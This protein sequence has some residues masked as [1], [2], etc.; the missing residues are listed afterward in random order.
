VDPRRWPHRCA[1]SRAR[2]GRWY[3]SGPGG[4]TLRRLGR[5]RSDRRAAGG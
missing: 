1:R 5:R 4:S 2:N 3:R